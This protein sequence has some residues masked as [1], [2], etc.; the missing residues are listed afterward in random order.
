MTRLGTAKAVARQVWRQ[1][2]SDWS[3]FFDKWSSVASESIALEG[4]ND[5]DETLGIDDEE[6]WIAF[7]TENEGQSIELDN[8]SDVVESDGED[9]GDDL[10]EYLQDEEADDPDQRDADSVLSFSTTL[11]HSVTA[12]SLKGNMSILERSQKE[13]YETFV[14]TFVHK[15]NREYE[16]ENQETAD[17]V[18]TLLDGIIESRQISRQDSGP[19][20]A[21]LA[22]NSIIFC[23][24]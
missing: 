7:P 16:E 4:E 6:E 1:R 24:F 2:T 9:D 8:A 19:P 11:N 12:G 15:L 23:F 14:E 18:A 3:S 22:T 13:M 21:G 5:G 10:L 17:D 20:L